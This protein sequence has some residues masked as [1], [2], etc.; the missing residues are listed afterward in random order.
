M[1]FCIIKSPC[2]VGLCLEVFKKKSHNLLSPFWFQRTKVF[3]VTFS[4]LKSV[5]E[6]NYLTPNLPLDEY[7]SK[8]Q[9]LGVK[10]RGVLTMFLELDLFQELL[11]C[12]PSLKLGTAHTY[13]YVWVVPGLLV[14]SMES[15]HCKLYSVSNAGTTALRRVGFGGDRIHAVF[16][17]RSIGASRAASWHSGKLGGQCPV[18]KKRPKFFLERIQVHLRTGN[19]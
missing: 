2:S 9:V 6:R 8:F 18:F 7:L 1:L 16:F 12:Q 15:S 14:V 10:A 19:L 4:S 11:V 13:A 17:M 5:T 3:K